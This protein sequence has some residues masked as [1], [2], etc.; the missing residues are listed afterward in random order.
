M[1]RAKK[2]FFL[3]FFLKRFKVLL[4]LSASRFPYLLIFIDFCVRFTAFVFFPGIH[5]QCH[6]NG[7]DVTNS[8][9]EALTFA[10]KV[11]EEIRSFCMSLLTD[12]YTESDM[13]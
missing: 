7:F 10:E 1:I 4:N 9:P 5:S 8:K 12:F 2:D 6:Q 11:K 3:Y 13:L